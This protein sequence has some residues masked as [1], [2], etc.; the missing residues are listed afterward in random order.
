MLA[1]FALD[2]LVGLDDE[3]VVDDVEPFCCFA[4]AWNAAKLLGPDSTEFT[5][6]T[7]P[8][9]QWP[10]CLQYAQIGVVS[11]T[12]MFHVGKVVAPSATGTNPESN[13]TWPLVD[14]KV[15]ARQGVANDDCVTVWFFCWNWNMITSPTCAVILEGV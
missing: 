3:A 11:L 6:K 10:L 2:L 8:E 15:K 13:P 5:L 14:V 1:P 9:P 4:A 7:M 12:V